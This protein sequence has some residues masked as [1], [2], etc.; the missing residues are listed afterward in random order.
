MGRQGLGIAKYLETPKGGR[1]R[2]GTLRSNNH[3]NNS[4]AFCRQSNCT[5]AHH[6]Q[7]SLLSPIADISLPVM[8]TDNI[9]QSEEY[10]MN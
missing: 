10:L 8:C 3:N 2:E 6:V 9:Y 4:E 7:I 1:G 5:V